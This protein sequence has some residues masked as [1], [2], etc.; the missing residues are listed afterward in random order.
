MSDSSNPPGSENNEIDPYVLLNV[1][2]DADFKAIKD[3][4]FMYSRVFHPDKQSAGVYLESRE[5][6]EVIDRAYKAI[7]TP[8]LKLIYDRFGY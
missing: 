5:Q 8:F 3:R 2:L 1:P 6:F 4:Y 7:S